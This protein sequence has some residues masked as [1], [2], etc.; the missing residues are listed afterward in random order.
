LSDNVQRCA[1]PPMELTRW[2]YLPKVTWKRNAFPCFLPFFSK[3]WF[4]FQL[5]C[6]F[7]RYKSS[8]C[9]CPT[10]YKPLSCFELLSRFLPQGDYTSPRVYEWHKWRH[11]IILMNRNNPNI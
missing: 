9:F 2:Y 4:N 11:H 1:L 7:S 6:S 8:N 3:L 10:L 5:K